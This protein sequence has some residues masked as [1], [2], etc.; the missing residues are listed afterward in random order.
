MYI[1]QD[2]GPW[3][4]SSEYGDPEPNQQH[5]VVKSKIA[6]LKKLLMQ[7]YSII[8]PTLIYL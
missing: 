5:P 4:I 6:I 2:D 3:L 8:L 1:D 7:V